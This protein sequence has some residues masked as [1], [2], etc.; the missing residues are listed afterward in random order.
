MTGYQK[1]P[2]KVAPDVVHTP[3]EGKAAL[4]TST[5]AN[6]HRYAA[7]LCM[8]CSGRMLCLAAAELEEYAE[9]TYGGALFVNGERRSP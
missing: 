1:K 6:D 7:K 4:F 2:T 8:S 5:D 9:G 3:C